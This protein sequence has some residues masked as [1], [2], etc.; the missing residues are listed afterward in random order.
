MTYGYAALVATDF[1]FSALQVS[2][3][4][5]FSSTSVCEVL[6][7]ELMSS[8]PNVAIFRRFDALV[9]WNLLKL[10]AVLMSIEKELHRA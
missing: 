10:H 6:L 5:I 3:L 9:I 4:L 7:A 2:V 8:Y 1:P